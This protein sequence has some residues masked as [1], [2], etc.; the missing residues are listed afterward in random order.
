VLGTCP[1]TRKYSGTMAS[2]IGLR[3][4]SR[5]DSAGHSTRV[6]DREGAARRH[7]GWSRARG[8]RYMGAK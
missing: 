6:V 5:T 8:C 4:W 2:T 7:K 1:Q 3:P